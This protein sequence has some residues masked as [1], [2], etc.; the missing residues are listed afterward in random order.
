MSTA[1][2]GQTALLAITF[3]GVN[4]FPTKLTG[5]NWV[6]TFSPSIV[7]SA[8]IGFTRTKWQHSLG[9]C[10]FAHWPGGN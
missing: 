4:I 8:R 7:N 9:G 1:Y 6:H 2:D 10:F 5:A 3:P